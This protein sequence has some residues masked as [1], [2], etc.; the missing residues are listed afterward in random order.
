MLLSTL[1]EVFYHDFTFLEV[2]KLKKVTSKIINLEFIW[3]CKKGM[4]D[5]CSV[6]GVF[7]IFYEVNPWWRIAI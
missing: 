1:K 6:Q 7:F 4:D 3:L 2:K 5:L